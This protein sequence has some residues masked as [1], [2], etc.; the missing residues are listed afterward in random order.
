M[1]KTIV[2]LLLAASLQTMV[3]APVAQAQ[4]ASGAALPD[5]AVAHPNR[6]FRKQSP[7][8]K[9]LTRSVRRQ[10]AKLKGVDVSDVSVSSRNGLV[11][12]TGTVQRADESQQLGQAVQGMTGVNAVINSLTIRTRM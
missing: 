10:I 8:D 12:L 7:E 3:T 5:D 6:Y 2:A 11:R 4:S 1:R 9:Q